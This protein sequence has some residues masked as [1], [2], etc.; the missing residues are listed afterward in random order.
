MVD[1]RPK[2]IYI[3]NKVIINTNSATPGVVVVSNCCNGYTYYDLRDNT[4][5]QWKLN[6]DGGVIEETINPA[7]NAG[8]IVGTLT[9]L[10][11]SPI[12]GSTSIYFDQ[13]DGNYIDCSSNPA[14]DSDAARSYSCWFKVE[15]IADGSWGVPL[16]D[17]PTDWAQGFVLSVY[18]NGAA[19]TLDVNH[20]GSFNEMNV[21]IVLNTWYHVVIT[22]NGTDKLASLYLDGEY[23][24]VTTATSTDSTGNLRIGSDGGINSLTFNG[25]VDNVCVF[26][27]VLSQYEIYFLHNSG[28]GT[29]GLSNV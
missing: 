1:I 14:F 13:G 22:Y 6:D 28:N 5:A 24:A 7:T 18:R 19:Y 21:P 9:Y 15:A 20:Q 26:D 12:A 17:S 4:L 23:K 16:C 27:K 25:Y 2:V 8:V 29:L 10:Q 11:T 3:N